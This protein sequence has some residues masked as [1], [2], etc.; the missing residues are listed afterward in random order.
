MRWAWRMRLVRSS[1]HVLL[2]DCRYRTFRFKHT[3]IKASTS[4]PRK[5]C[6]IWFGHYRTV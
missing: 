5:T 3:N 2:E 1:F 4:V 6:E